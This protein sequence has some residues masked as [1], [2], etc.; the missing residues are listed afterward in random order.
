MSTE[1]TNYMQTFD[2]GIT[3]YA[4]YPTESNVEKIKTLTGLYHTSQGNIELKTLIEK[5]LVEL[6]EKL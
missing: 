6:I 1:N 5:K 4:Y 3:T 2:S